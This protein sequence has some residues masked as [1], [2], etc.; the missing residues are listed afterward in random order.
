MHSEL[1]V[2]FGDDL[3]KESDYICDLRVHAEFSVDYA[4]SQLSVPRF[5]D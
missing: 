4:K 3:L 2:F 1:G 5:F